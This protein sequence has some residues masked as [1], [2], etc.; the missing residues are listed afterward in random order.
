MSAAAGLVHKGESKN[1]KTYATI[2]I[3]N[4][5]KGKSLE[6]PKSSAIGASKHGLQSLGKVQ[7]G[8]RMPPPALLPSLKSENLG[9]NPNVTLVPTGGQGWGVAKT[10]QPGASSTGSGGN[11][12]GNGNNNTNNSSTSSNLQSSDPPIAH[13]ENRSAV[14]ENGQ[15]GKAGCQSGGGAGGNKTWS[16]VATGQSHGQQNGGHGGP[17]G[18]PQLPF[19]PGEFPTLKNE[20]EGKPAGGSLNSADRD[21]HVANQYGPGLALRPVES[22]WSKGSAGVSAQL[23]GGSPQANAGSG[24]NGLL[25]PRPLSPLGSSPNDP[26]GMGYPPSISKGLGPRER[27]S[28]L[29][30]GTAP[31]FSRGEREERPGHAERQDRGDGRGGG[32]MGGPRPG[33][34][35]R[36]FQRDDPRLGPD[37][38]SKSVLKHSAIISDQQ[39]EGFDRILKDNETDW[40]TAKG[41][42]DY[43]AKLC[44]SE[45]EDDEKQLWTPSGQQDRDDG[46]REGRHSRLKDGG[47]DNRSRGPMQ[48]CVFD[49][50]SQDRQGDSGNSVWRNKQQK[51]KNEMNECVERARMMRRD[52]E[53]KLSER[54]DVQSHVDQYQ[55]SDRGGN[56][57][58]N[59]GNSRKDN[60][61]QQQLSSGSRGRVEKQL[62]PRFAKMQ[63][64][65][66]SSRWSNNGAS[67]SSGNNRSRSDSSSSNTNNNSNN[68]NAA[69]NQDN[70]CSLMGSQQ[71]S[72][73]QM[74]KENK[75]RSLHDEKS[76]SPQQSSQQQQQQQS[77]CL[78]QQPDKRE[79]S[80]WQDQGGLFDPPPRLKNNMHA[81]P[82]LTLTNVAD[83]EPKRNLT[84]LKKDGSA[85]SKQKDDEG[86]DKGADEMATRMSHKS[87]SSDSLK[88]SSGSQASRGTSSKKLQDN[89]DGVASNDEEQRGFSPRGEPSRRGRGGG[90][91]GGGGNGTGS[92]APMRGSGRPFGE[93][94]GA[95]VGQKGPSGYP[96]K[97]M[98]SRGGRGGGGSGAGGRGGPASSRHG[99]SLT[100]LSPQDRNQKDD[101]P[102]ARFKRY[103]DHD[104]DDD[105]KKFGG[106]SQ[107]TRDSR[108]K[109]LAGGS[110]RQQ[111]N[112][113]PNDRKDTRRDERRETSKNGQQPQDSKKQE[114]KS[115]LT[116][117]DKKVPQDSKK[118]DNGSASGTSPGSATSVG[119][120]TSLKK[121]QQQQQQAQQL[122]SVG[123]QSAGGQK[124]AG[125]TSSSTPPQKKEIGSS[126]SLKKEGAW[127]DSEVSPGIEFGTLGESEDLNFKIQAVKKVWETDQTTSSHPAQSQSSQASGVPTS[128][129]NVQQMS[130]V[131]QQS[132]A[133]QQQ[134]QQ[135]SA[136][137]SQ[138]AQISFF[139]T[140]EKETSSSPMQVGQSAAQAV[141]QQDLSTSAQHMVSSLQQAYAN[142]QQQSSKQAQQQQQQQKY[143]TAPAAAVQ[144]HH[145]LATGYGSLSQSPID[146]SQ[147]HLR[148]FAQP[149]AGAA[150][151]YTTSF[152]NPPPAPG[153]QHMTNS[154]A[155]AGT[156]ASNDHQY[157]YFPQDMFRYQQQTQ[158]NHFRNFFTTQTGPFGATQQGYHHQMPHYPPPNMQQTFSTGIYAAAGH[159][160]ATAAATAAS[161]YAVKDAQQPPYEQSTPPPYAHSQAPQQGGQA[162]VVAAAAAN[163]S[164]AGT[165]GSLGG[166]PAKQPGGAGAFGAASSGLFGS[167][168]RAQQQYGQPMMSQSGQPS[169]ARQ[170][171]NPSAGGQSQRYAGKS[172]GYSHH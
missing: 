161:R 112:G 106:R 104:E 157:T 120:L 117:K 164:T 7:V 34:G 84:S 145:P 98:S 76:P 9:N 166:V 87:V 53:R 130:Q 16:S 83:I 127:G 100:Q 122:S 109:P 46:W 69:S 131:A 24:V 77:D 10:S 129:A 102:P 105:D 119:G 151:M 159:A 134:Q 140:M 126:S 169:V 95:P 149:H 42:I 163:R 167:N 40:S 51:T 58:N 85:G 79:P 114:N 89:S 150:Q 14:G 39:L 73:W 27:Q 21:G 153:H 20:P 97:D 61:S 137:Q 32:G 90:R 65:Q 91:G 108:D 160:P 56:L 43:N 33:G 38:H 47:R 8:R 72:V 59:S 88:G 63:L 142:S 133:Q 74:N 132:A 103:D 1:K 111:R 82:P 139:Q 78:W 165:M 45:D 138:Q 68:N 6:G 49:E 93:N 29:T 155:P 123:Q 70:N 4:I 62:P 28:P 168:Q 50:D 66:D 154:Q 80:A 152:Q 30:N 170:N 25:K 94:R 124:V 57:N 71:E 26:L 15:P 148:A 55:S 92:A 75:Q 96:S 118:S 110:G 64:A 99:P 48:Q 41:D 11:G 12:A 128:A 22:N 101:T 171:P 35:G 60:N 162:A 146:P 136:A 125:V 158:Q 116:S 5:Y 13:Q 143:H 156:G 17:G 44:F 19:Y 52:S 135:H 18:G 3:N 121:D 115:A 81:G 144:R 172:S 141:T 147:H 86:I 31:L 113:G 2:D 107:G 54:D 67:G 36:A 23:S 37:Q